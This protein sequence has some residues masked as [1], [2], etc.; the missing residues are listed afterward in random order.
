MHGGAARVLIILHD[1]DHVERWWGSDP[2]APDE[3][4]MEVSQ[5]D[6]STAFWRV[7]T[8][9]DGS[10][11]ALLQQTATRADSERVLDR[12]TL[13]R[14]LMETHA[15]TINGA[16]EYLADIPVAVAAERGTARTRL[17]VGLLR[18]L[19]H[20]DVA[21]SMAG[22]AWLNALCGR[23]RQPWRRLWRWWE[24]ILIRFSKVTTTWSWCSGGR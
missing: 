16:S 10:F 7:V 9:V 18:T 21:V 11:A 4:A 17:E 22:I 13:V 14:Q 24:R 20:A 3:S 8:A 12:L 6:A 1:L 23:K 19:A 15:A 2:A 5:L